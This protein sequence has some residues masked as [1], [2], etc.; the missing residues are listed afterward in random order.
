[1][2]KTIFCA[3][4]HKKL[5]VGKKIAAITKAPPGLSISEFSAQRRA[6]LPFVIEVCD[7]FA[8]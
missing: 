2:Q 4:A 5:P 3:Q 6:K 7:A 8:I 1:L